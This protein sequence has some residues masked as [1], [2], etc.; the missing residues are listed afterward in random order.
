MTV[1][2]ILSAKGSDVVSIE[3]TATLAAAA[4]LLA[5]RRIGSLVVLGAGGRRSGVLSERDI[6]RMI[7]ELGAA[8]LDQPVGQVMTRTVATCSPDDSIE[9]IMERMTS[10]KFRHMPVLRQSR[11]AGIVSIGDVVK[12]RLE[13]MERETE[14]MRDYIQSA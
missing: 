6:V 3:P 11:L 5:A 14:A 2:A 13:A 1:T 12:D 9:S 7:G 4:K 10:G 8:A